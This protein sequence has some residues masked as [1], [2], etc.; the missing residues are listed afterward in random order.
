MYLFHI[1]QHDYID[2]IV[3]K[4]YYMPIRRS[5]MDENRYLTFASGENSIVIDRIGGQLVSYKVRGVEVLSQGELDPASSPWKATAKN[6]FPNPGQVGGR[7]QNF[8]KRVDEDRSYA[9]AMV[10]ELGAEKAVEEYVKSSKNAKEVRYTL[11]GIPYRIS[12]HGFAQDMEFR[13]RGK[14]KN[15]CVLSIETSP[16]TLKQYPFRFRYNLGYEI[17]ENGGLQYDA[18]CSNLD[19]RAI[20]AGMGWHPAFLLHD[21]KRVGRYKIIFKNLKKTADCPIREDEYYPIESIVEEGKTV[22]IG[23]IISAD[24]VLEYVFSDGHTYE[25]VTMHTEE[26][27]LILWSKPLTDENQDKFICI[28]PW[29][30]E[31]KVLGNLSVQERTREIEGAN[32]IEPNQ[33]SQISASVNIGEEY[34]RVLEKLPELRNDKQEDPAMLS[35]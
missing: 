35:R 33:T 29:N 26:P 13:V 23:G 12:Q 18:S 16:E 9:E 27:R 2:F 30:T 19:D 25:Y 21:K 1:K 22:S 34:I 10:E 6:L 4:W 5:K 17:D 15:G 20:V 8:A 14:Q 32:I 3:T 24:V 31:S 7:F 11:N 28:E